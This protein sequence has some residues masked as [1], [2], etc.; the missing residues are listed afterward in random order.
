MLSVII[1]THDSE[2]ALLPTLAALVP[3]AMDGLVTEVVVADGGSR[4]ETARIADVAGCTFL[5]APGALGSRLKSAAA[6]ARAPWFLFLRP[7]TVPD[8][9]WIAAARRF[10]ERSTSNSRAAVFQRSTASRP[11][12]R[13]LKFL[14]AAAL[15]ARPGPAQGLLI[16]RE[17]YDTLGGHRERA[18]DPE[19]DL[20]RRIG[21]RRI[22]TLAGTAAQILD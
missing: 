6:A 12:L 10:V 1:P 19:A 9:S 17:F 14:L 2:R 21:R 8:A 5:V 18:A 22:A 13:D 11:A 4:D 16:A 20:V 7:G 15:G 3:A